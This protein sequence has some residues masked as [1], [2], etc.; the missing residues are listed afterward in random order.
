LMPHQ[1]SIKRLGIHG[2]DEGGGVSLAAALSKTEKGWSG[3]GRYENIHRHTRAR[4]R[5]HTHT[6]THTHTVAVCL[7]ARLDASS[8]ALKRLRQRRGADKSYRH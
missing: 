8:R 4:A 2:E 3:G 6:H 1:G 7:G 5:T